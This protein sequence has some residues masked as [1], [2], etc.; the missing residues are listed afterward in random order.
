MNRYCESR[1]TTITVWT[2]AFVGDIAIINRYHTVSIRNPLSSSSSSSL[3]SSSPSSS[4]SSLSSSSSSS[5]SLSSLSPTATVTS[6][7]KPTPSF[8]MPG[9]LGKSRVLTEAKNHCHHHR[10]HDYQQHIHHHHRHQQQQ[11]QQVQR[12]LHSR[13]QQ[14][15]IAGLGLI[16]LLFIL[17]T[18]FLNIV[19]G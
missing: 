7:S 19:L 17:Q 1:T 2:P 5:S 16:F 13:K 4:S 10:Y 8:K 18:F 9:L 11:Q 3:S 14:L 12:R 15:M 6:S